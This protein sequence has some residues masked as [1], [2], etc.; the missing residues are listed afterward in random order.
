MKAMLKFY[1][2]PVDKLISSVNEL[3]LLMSLQITSKSNSGE[4]FS[5]ITSAGHNSQRQDVYVLI[6]IMEGVN[7]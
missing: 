1:L 2:H 6:L 4:S 3:E 5:L 7:Y